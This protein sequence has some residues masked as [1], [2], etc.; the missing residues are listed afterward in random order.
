MKMCTPGDF[1][2]LTAMAAFQEGSIVWAKLR[3]FPWWPAKVFCWLSVT[4]RS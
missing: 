4:Q 3:G 2:P 1:T